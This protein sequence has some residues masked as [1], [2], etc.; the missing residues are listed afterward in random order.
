MSE[1]IPSDG[2]RRSLAL[3]KVFRLEQTDPAA[4]YTTLA[5]DSV[6]QLERYV[7]LAGPLL[8]D[9]GGGP[10]Y[11]A[12]AFRAAGAVYLSL[13]SDVGEMSL[14]GRR[15]L[16]GTSVLGTGVHLP[17]ADASVDI[18][19]SSNVLEHVSDPWR[20]A[21]EMVRVTRPGGIVFIS[22]TNWLS[23]HGGHETGMWHY[24]GGG[25]AR[26]RYA[27]RHGRPPKNSFGSSLF[28]VSVADAFRWV[29][30]QRHAELI[31][32]VPRYH[33]RWARGVVRVPLLRE[34]AT[35]NVTVVMRRQPSQPSRV[36]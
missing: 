11:F 25:Y 16:V 26:D 34:V 7:D 19:Y 3:L 32:I 14:H 9:V 23:P 6:A 29:D 30:R 10:G 8:L 4:F 15:P 20:M 17:F 22:Y 31:E 21:D 1:R 12:D 24:V 2:V 35:W 36:P 13:D 27:R 28:A 18:S 5:D 33:P